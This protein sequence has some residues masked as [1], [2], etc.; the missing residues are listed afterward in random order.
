MQTANRSERV[1]RADESL[2]CGFDWPKA[3]STSRLLAP[4]AAALLL[5][6]GVAYRAKRAQRNECNHI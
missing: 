5:L 4:A 3:D 6:P 2:A 1:A